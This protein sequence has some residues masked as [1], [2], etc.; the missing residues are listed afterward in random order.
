MTMD[1]YFNSS[2][3]AL[4]YDTEGHQV[5]GNAHVKVDA[6]DATSAALID[7]GL[8]ILVE[9]KSEQKA[10]REAAQPEPVKAENSSKSARKDT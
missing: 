10:E 1:R 9:S 5:D 4:V 2:P 8:L 3:G 6:D 7:A